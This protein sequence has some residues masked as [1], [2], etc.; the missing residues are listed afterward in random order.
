MDNSYGSFNIKQ[1]TTLFKLPFLILY[2]LSSSN[3][4]FL[5]VHSK[6]TLPSS[7][8]PIISKLIFLIVSEARSIHRYCFH[9][10]MNKQHSTKRIIHSPTHSDQV[11]AT[12]TEPCC[13]PWCGAHLRAEP[14]GLARSRWASPLYNIWG[15][16]DHSNP[17]ISGPQV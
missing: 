5:I 17:F 1:E 9:S 7:L 3:R 8:C 11:R 14:L 6:T 12:C 13:A 2:A 16:S 4:I 15:P 10:N